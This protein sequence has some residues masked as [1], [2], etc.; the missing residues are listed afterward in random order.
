[1][2]HVFIPEAPGYQQDLASFTHS[3]VREYCLVTNDLEATKAA[4]TVLNLIWS[5]GWSTEVGIRVLTLALP[6][7]GK[8]TLGNSLQLP[9]AYFLFPLPAACLYSDFRVRDCLSLCD[10]H[11]HQMCQRK[12][13]E[14]CS[15]KMWGDLPPPF[16]LLLVSWG[17]IS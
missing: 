15:R 10:S 4:K 17:R 14:T 8:L 5:S 7:T 13:P 9:I 16:D 1:M 2:L 3:A 11:Q 6:L 12:V